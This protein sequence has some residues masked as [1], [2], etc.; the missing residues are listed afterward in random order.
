MRGFARAAIVAIPALVGG[1]SHAANTTCTSLDIRIR[2]SHGFTGNRDFAHFWRRNTGKARQ[3]MQLQRQRLR[4]EIDLPGAVQLQVGGIQRDASEASHA[5]IE[6]ANDAEAAD[7]RL[8][9][10]VPVL[11]QG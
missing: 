10:R 11:L 3:R 7:R 5:R 4:P 1:A 8:A 9:L 6:R 2:G